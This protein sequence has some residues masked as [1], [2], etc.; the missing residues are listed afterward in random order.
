MSVVFTM[1]Y[2]RADNPWAKDRKWKKDVDGTEYFISTRMDLLDI[3]FI[4]TAFGTDDMYWAKTIP[5]DQITAMLALSTTLGLYKVL[6]AGPP[7]KSG[8]SPSSPQTPSP[9]LEDVPNSQL[10]MIGMARLMTDHVT[11]AYLTDVYVLPEYR[12]FGLGRWLIACC[13]D[14]IEDMP[15]MRR[16]FLMASP[17]EGKR[18]Y[19]RELGFWDVGEEREYALCMTKRYRPLGKQEGEG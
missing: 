10:E 16:A 4:Y 7:A 9:T 11:S 6:P 1:N 5:K 2:S 14:F 19:E 3:D 12:K 17:G 13:N 18:F 8:D 15:A